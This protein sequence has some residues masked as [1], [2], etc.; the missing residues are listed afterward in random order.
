MSRFARLA[1]L[2]A[3]TG[4]QNLS[5][6]AIALASPLP[7][8]DFPIGDGKITLLPFAKTASGTFGDGVRKPTNTIVDFYVEQIVNLPGQQFDSTINAGR[9]YAVFRI[10]YEDVEQ[11]N[12]HDMDAIVR[13]LIIANAVWHRDGTL[14][15]EYHRCAAQTW[16]SSG[17][18]NHEDASI[19]MC[20]IPIR[21]AP[22]GYARILPTRSAGGCNRHAAAAA[23]AVAG[24][25]H[26]YLTPGGTGGATILENPLFYAAKYGA[27]T[28]TANDV[29]GDGVPDNY[30]LV[31]NP[32]TLRAQLDK[33]FADIIANSQPTAS[34]ATST[35]RF[36]PGATLAYEA[37]YRSLDWS[38]D[39]KAYNLRSDATYDSGTE[40]WSASG[41]MPGPDARNVFTAE[42]ITGGFDG[43]PFTTSGLSTGLQALVQGTLDPGV[44]TL[45]ELIDYLRGDKA[46]EQGVTGCTVTTDCPY[47]ARSSKIGD[48]LN[49]TP[50]VIGVTSFGYG[51]ILRDFAPTA[52]AS[53]PAYVEAKKTIFGDTSQTPILFVG[54]NDGMLHAFDGRAGSGGGVEL[55]AYI[56]NAVLPNLNLLAQPG[57]VHR[58]FVDGSPTVTDAYLGSWKTVLAAS[59]GAGARA[60][61]ALDV[62]NPRASTLM[63]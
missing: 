3:A 28:P 16:A 61:Y 11:G 18:A 52:A 45:D 62:S 50:A 22:R 36:V 14:N 5:T 21:T 12:D 1:D 40:V 30:F 7:R 48:I 54:A 55:F 25:L 59:T 17:P 27:P 37:S 32:A 38:G 39:I 51:G 31:T 42:P 15:S 33:A 34:V 44:F 24:Q 49:S 43:V 4:Q 9:P 63:T 23:I 13:Y 41:R 57:Y 46:N 6:Y 19:S 20:A 47:R 56:P 58:Y 26:A 8:I 53:Y 29:D 60:V 2:N 10:N 35:P